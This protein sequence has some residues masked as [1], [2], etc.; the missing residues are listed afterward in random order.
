MIYSFDV[1]DCYFI[2]V[3][4]FLKQWSIHFCSKIDSITLCE[5]RWVQKRILT[6][7]MHLIEAQICNAY[8]CGHYDEIVF[9]C[10]LFRHILTLFVLPEAVMSI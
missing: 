10:Q 5:K 8:G 1:K 3:D 6:T 4:T 2:N 7:A 9:E